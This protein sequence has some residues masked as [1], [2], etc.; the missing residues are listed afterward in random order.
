[1]TTTT[2]SAT[3]AAAARTTTTT[4]TA[5]AAAAS[6]NIHNFREIILNIHLTVSH[7]VALLLTKWLQSS[8]N[9]SVAW[10]TL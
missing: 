7:L 9:C 2:T 4:A 8:A 1:M 10:T 5:A 3:A 6:G